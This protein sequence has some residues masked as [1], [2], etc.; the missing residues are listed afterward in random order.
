MDKIKYG[1][2]TLDESMDENIGYQMKL[3]FDYSIK[4]TM[5]EMELQ[6]EM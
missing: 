3:P 6:K 4:V 2:D 5:P 1:I